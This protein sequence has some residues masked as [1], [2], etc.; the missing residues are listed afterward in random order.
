MV[1]PVCCI[2]EGY[3]G[4]GSKDFL[5]IVVQASESV[6]NFYESENP[7]NTADYGFIQYI[8]VKFGLGLY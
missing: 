2:P 6:V 4:L 3:I 1:I 8:G 5:N 7:T